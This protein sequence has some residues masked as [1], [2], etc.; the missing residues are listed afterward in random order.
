M[1]ADSVQK[2]KQLRVDVYREQKDVRKE[3]RTRV[4]AT[5]ATADPRKLFASWNQAEADRKEFILWLRQVSETLPDGGAKRVA[6]WLLRNTNALG[7][8]NPYLE[9]MGKK[10]IDDLARAGVFEDAAKTGAKLA[11]GMDTIAAAEITKQGKE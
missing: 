11:K 7:G 1:N 8:M 6:L 9:A 2:A 5:M 4:D 10:V 3:I